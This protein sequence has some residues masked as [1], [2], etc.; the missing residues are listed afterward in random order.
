VPRFPAVLFAY[1]RPDLLRRTLA[2]LEG[3][4]IELLIAFSDAPAEPAFTPDVEEVRRLLRAVRW[5]AVR[6]VER[7]RNLGL[8]L[9]IRSGVEEV[10]REFS[11]VVVFEDDLICAPGAYRFAVAAL[12]HYENVERVMSVT[13]WT[14]PRVVPPGVKDA[15]YFD[16]RAECWVWGTWPRAWRGMELTAQ[17][18]IEDCLRQ[19]IDPYR[20]GRDLV[21]MAAE[22]S[23]RNIWAVRWLYH[24]IRKG[25]LCLRPPIS[26]VTHIGEDGRGTNVKQPMSDWGTGSIEGALPA[27]E[28]PA[29]VE[30]PACAT[31]WREAVGT[32]P[33][34]RDTLG[35][36]LHA[37]FRRALGAVRRR[38]GRGRTMWAKPAD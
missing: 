24:H 9:S 7:E 4:G 29:A 38:L 8:G 2:A 26:L 16:G 32:W 36:R 11:G 35:S 30:N 15:A 21:A 13:A 27:L 18:M 17:E 10:L 25:G 33:V 34:S 31:L 5:A 20:Y 1:R 28:W 6:L 12:E 37:S 19:R 3:Q 23:A 14:H 22:E